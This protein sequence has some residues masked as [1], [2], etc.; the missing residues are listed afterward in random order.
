[1]EDSRL[2]PMQPLVGGGLVG[3]EQELIDSD[4]SSPS[5]S[6]SLGCLVQSRIA[7]EGP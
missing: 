5:V 1:M 4:L 3:L 6:T 7:L 2:G